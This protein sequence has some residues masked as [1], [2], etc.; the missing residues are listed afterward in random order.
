MTVG[1]VPVPGWQRC[2]G[3]ALTRPDH[4]GQV[5]IRRLKD[6]HGGTVAVSEQ[7]DVSTYVCCDRS[8]RIEAGLAL[9]HPSVSSQNSSKSSPGTHLR[10]TIVVSSEDVRTASGR[11]RR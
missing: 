8:G 1:K 7:E 2:G 4:H 11:G 3:P 6:R 5:G 9:P 10:N